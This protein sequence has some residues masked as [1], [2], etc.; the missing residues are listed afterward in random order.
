M[1][2]VQMPNEDRDAT[3][4][5]FR[6]NTRARERQADVLAGQILE[7][8]DDGSNDYIQTEE[9]GEVRRKAHSRAEKRLNHPVQSALPA[10]QRAAGDVS[11]IEA[12]AVLNEVRWTTPAPEHEALCA[13]CLKEVLAYGNAKA[14]SSDTQPDAQLGVRATRAA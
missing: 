11:A 10:L 4:L 14:K 7:I 5:S 3:L 12:Q 8:S 2:P 13:A 9:G 6:R 1:A